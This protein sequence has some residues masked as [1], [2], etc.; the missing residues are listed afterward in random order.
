VTSAGEALA[1]REPVEA[2]RAAAAFPPEVVYVEPALDPTPP[3][4]RETLW[5]APAAPAS[6][7]GWSP[8]RAGTP[9]AGTYRQ[10]AEE[11]DEDAPYE[12]P[13]T[14]AL[15]L[16]LVFAAIAWLLAQTFVAQ[17]VGNGAVDRD[18]AFRKF[19][20]LTGLEAPQGQQSGSLATL[21]GWQ[22]VMLD[23]H[24]EGE[25]RAD[26]LG[27]AVWVF[28]QGN[29][30][31]SS[32]PEEL[33]DE[34]ERKVELQMTQKGDHPDLQGTGARAA[35]WRVGERRGQLRGSP[36]LMRTLA[37]GAERGGQRFEGARVAALA[38]TSPH[39]RPALLVI[40]GPTTRV[41]TLQRAYMSRMSS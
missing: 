28:E 20:R 16:A 6:H 14:R 17:E 35:W 31:G 41:S 3:P 34:V 26:E 33:L 7:S 30:A 21:A 29:L 8:P 40:F 39:G 23:E 25:E 18:E 5:E 22:V 38:F 32:T 9:T 13:L 1:A 37:I 2:G 11:V 24:G 10:P 15:P 12:T 27:L 19:E 36:V 4:S